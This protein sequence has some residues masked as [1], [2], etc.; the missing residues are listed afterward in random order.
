MQVWC[1][2]FRAHIDAMV[3]HTRP[4]H[5]SRRD[6]APPAHIFSSAVVKAAGPPRGGTSGALRKRGGKRATIIARWPRNFNSGC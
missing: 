4:G 2:C 1:I 6:A 5:I 3:L